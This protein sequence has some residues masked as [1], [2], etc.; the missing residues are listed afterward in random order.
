MQD[1]RQHPSPEPNRPTKPPQEERH[2]HGFRP[3]PVPPPKPIP[4][5]N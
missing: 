4:P 3:P 5:K 2:D 1:K